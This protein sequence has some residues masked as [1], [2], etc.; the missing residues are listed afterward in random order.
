L[1]GGTPS[2]FSAEAL[3]QVLTALNQHFDFTNTVEI[4]LEANP[5]TVDLP[6]LKEFQAAG[7]NRISL[8]VQSLQ[9]AYLGAFGRIHTGTEA[10][11]ALE[12][13]L[14]AGFERVNAD[15]IFGFPGQTFKEWQNDVETILKLGL[16][17]LSC[18]SLMA[19]SGTIFTRDVKAGKIAET[20]PEIFA[21]MLEWTHERLSQAGLPSYEVSNF[22]KVG[23]ES[24][25]NQAYW[26]FHSYLGL[27]AGAC[28]QNVVFES[29]PSV[30]RTVNVK[31]PD[32]YQERVRQGSDFFD[33]ENVDS[34]TAMK[35]FVLMGLRTQAG[36]S[37]ENF[38]ALFAT[39]LASVFGSAITKHIQKGHL[40]WSGSNLKPTRCGLFLNNTV[41]GDFF[42]SADSA[43]KYSMI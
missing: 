27:G 11:L 9:D 42:T 40:I 41:V 12:A 21:D 29:N 28:G 6:K 38:R 10:L 36:L 43:R 15:L 22:A 3:S 37:D 31:S 20:H 26:G 18:Y 16:K 25:H 34:T 23:E 24:R 7:I 19:E 8:G 35:E 5:G 33:V 39:D 4:T 32:L 1:G 30:C 17:H 13:A 14:L 2:L